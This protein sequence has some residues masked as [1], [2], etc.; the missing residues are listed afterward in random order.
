M[1]FSLPN[2]EVKEGDG[3]KSEKG[4]GKETGP[5]SGP[6]QTLKLEWMR[7]FFLLPGCQWGNATGSGYVGYI[8]GPR[9]DFHLRTWLIKFKW[10]TLTPLQ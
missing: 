1:Y 4:H 2:E 8:Y 10:S 3:R 7:R 6:H 5:R 9:E